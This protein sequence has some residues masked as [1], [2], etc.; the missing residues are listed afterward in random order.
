MSPT[1]APPGDVDHYIAAFPIDVQRQLR[2]VR[3]AI[4]KA[5]PNA[6]EVI[7]YGMPAFV[8]NGIGLLSFAAWKNHIAIYPAP[9]G[10]ASFNKRLEPY[11]AEKSTVRFPLD[12]PIPVD[13]IAE[14]VKLRVREK[15]KRVGETPQGKAK[16]GRG[17]G[18]S[19]APHHR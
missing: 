18:T 19:A 3:T 10:S 11:R 7:S 13:L 9:T 2:R 8:L 12:E 16:V 17:P 4:K 14:I 15:A 6:H 5:A 1:N